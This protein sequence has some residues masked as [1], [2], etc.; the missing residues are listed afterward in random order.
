[1]NDVAVIK[2][3]PLRA[4]SDHLVFVTPL[5]AEIHVH[6]EPGER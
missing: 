5:S 4:L 6:E 2:T 3:I 1:M